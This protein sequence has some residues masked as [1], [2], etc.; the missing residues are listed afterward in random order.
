MG[1]PNIQLRMYETLTQVGVEPN[2]AH[3]LERDLETA[4][5]SGQEAV[6]A[7]MRELF[8]TKLDAEKLSSEMQVL[9]SEVKSIQAHMLTKADGESIKAD[10]RSIK[11]DLLKALNE[12]TWKLVSFVLVFNSLLVAL[13]VKFR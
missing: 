7:E 11:A 6:R 8:M 3:K 9:S 13:V 10:S 12:Q 1:M 4:F 2:F 5:N